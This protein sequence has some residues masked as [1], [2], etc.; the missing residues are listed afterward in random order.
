MAVAGHV[1]AGLI[2][3]GKRRINWF[4]R[5]PSGYLVKTARVAPLLY[6][7][8]FIIIMTMMMIMMMMMMRIKTY[9]I[10]LIM[11]NSQIL[12]T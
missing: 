2:A 9:F 11:S 7:Y 1:T 4:F 6:L 5:L 10:S 3:I 12:V 8:H